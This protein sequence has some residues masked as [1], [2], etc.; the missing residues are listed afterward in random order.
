MRTTSTF[1]YCL[2]WKS[3]DQP[4]WQSIPNSVTIDP[5]EIN[6]L[7][8]DMGA[9]N[10]LGGLVYEIRHRLI[11]RT[12]HDWKSGIPEEPRAWYDQQPKESREVNRS[13]LIRSVGSLQQDEGKKAV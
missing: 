1:E 9:L 3:D 8:R 4:F 2:F 6:L 13:G 10:H 12:E 7:L 11:T 5:K